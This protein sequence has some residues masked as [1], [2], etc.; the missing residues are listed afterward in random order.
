[1][2]NMFYSNKGLKK[3]TQ[4]SVENLKLQNNIFDNVKIM[5]R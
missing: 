2:Y 3:E 5:K 4:S 1:M